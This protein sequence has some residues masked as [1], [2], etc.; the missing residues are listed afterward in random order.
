MEA[1]ALNAHGHR[2]G[3]DGD[4]ANLGRPIVRVGDVVDVLAVVVVVATEDEG[5]G[6]ELEEFEC[7]LFPEGVLVPVAYPGSDGAPFA[8]GSAASTI[9]SVE[10]DVGEEDD[11]V[12]VFR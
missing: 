12:L 5:W 2:E 9:G 3:L 6:E 7:G 1:R 10:R 4:F 8:E 11:W